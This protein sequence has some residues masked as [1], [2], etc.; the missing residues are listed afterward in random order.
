MLRSLAAAFVKK[1]LGKRVT[2][3]H[4]RTSTSAANAAFVRN[5]REQFVILVKER[6]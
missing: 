3:K 2:L 4:T 5:S 6:K 1:P